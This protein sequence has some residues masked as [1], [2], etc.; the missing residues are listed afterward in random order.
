MD[1]TTRLRSY[2]SSIGFECLKKVENLAL[3]RKIDFSSVF[4]EERFFFEIDSKYWP[5]IVFFVGFSLETQNKHSRTRTL[6][7]WIF[8]SYNNT[9]TTSEAQRAKNGAIRP[10]RSNKSDQR[11]NE[12]VSAIIFMWIV[13]IVFIF[14]RDNF[15]SLS[16]KLWIRAAFTFTENRQSTN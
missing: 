7:I 5:S 2:L 12:N 4:R 13:L 8:I 3:N 6:Y 11:T 15:T 1:Q 10:V 16:Q 14:R 9:L